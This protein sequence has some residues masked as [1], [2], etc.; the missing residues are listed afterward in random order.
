MECDDTSCKHVVSSSPTQ[1]ALVIQKATPRL[2]RKKPKPKK[3]VVKT[4]LKLIKMGPRAIV[5]N[6]KRYNRILEG[7]KKAYAKFKGSAV[8]RRTAIRAC[9]TDGAVVGPKTIL[10]QVK[11]ITKAVKKGKLILTPGNCHAHGAGHYRTFDGKKYN[12][13]DYG[14]Y[15]LYK[16]R[17]FNEHVHVLMDS[18]EDGYPASFHTGVGVR[19]RS[20]RVALQFTN[21]RQRW[22]LSLQMD[23]KQRALVP[24][25]YESGSIRVQI[26]GR[27]SAMRNTDK[28]FMVLTNKYNDSE[29]FTSVKLWSAPVKRWGSARHKMMH[30]MD[31][32]VFTKGFWS[33]GKTGGLCGWVDKNPKND[34][35]RRDDKIVH[36]GPKMAV[37]WIAQPEERLLAA[38]RAPMT[39]KERRKLVA[40]SKKT[41]KA[42]LSGLLKH[43][44][45]SMGAIVAK[46]KK[47]KASCRA[48]LKKAKPVTIDF[49][50]KDCMLGIKFRRGKRERTS[51]RNVPAPTQ[52][53]R[54]PQCRVEAYLAGYR[55][56]RLDYSKSTVSNAKWEN[57]NG[58]YRFWK[59]GFRE[60]SLCDVADTELDAHSQS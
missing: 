38:R 52:C 48:R 44:R 28:A 12:W 36:T 47:C 1:S 40:W 55:Q 13:K 53:S 3:N 9:V 8:D 49:C 5:K 14:E 58:F 16:S 20:H 30:W 25:V 6:K 19:I 46:W 11:D 21:P 59:M 4:E 39:D 17:H 35:R 18:P 26:L 23:G 34:F 57:M 10:K 27:P 31:V 24:G 45:T 60:A 56:A 51:P 42:W 2:A 22:Q 41:G 29:M 37:T 33:K 32:H 54:N 15:I 50:A 7:C 43:A